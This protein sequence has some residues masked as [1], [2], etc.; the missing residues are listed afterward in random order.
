MPISSLGRKE[1]IFFLA[2]LA[3]GWHRTAEAISTVV[4]ENTYNGPP[5]G[6]ASCSWNFP[7]PIS[8]L[9]SFMEVVRLGNCG[10]YRG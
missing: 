3:S 7:I 4:G 9:R 2:E 10:G 5:P 1:I 8:T 6:S